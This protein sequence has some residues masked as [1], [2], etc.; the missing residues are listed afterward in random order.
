MSLEFLGDTMSLCY[1]SVGGGAAICVHIVT[2]VYTM[3]IEAALSSTAYLV[4]QKSL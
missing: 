4:R 3:G 2:E 1:S